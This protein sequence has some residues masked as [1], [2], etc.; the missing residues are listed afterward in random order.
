MPTPEEIQRTVARLIYAWEAQVDTDGKCYCPCNQ[1][2][3]LKRR[4][5]VRKIVER[6]FFTYGNCEGGHTFHPMVI[7]SLYMS[8]YLFYL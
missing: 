5:L 3:I 7:Y 8:L 2:T 1:C 6:H 4:K